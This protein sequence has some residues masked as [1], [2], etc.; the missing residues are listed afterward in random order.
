MKKSTRFTWK[1]LIQGKTTG[2]ENFTMRKTKYNH[3]TI[4]PDLAWECAETTISAQ[5]IDV[6][7]LLKL[8]K[9]LCLSLSFSLFHFSFFSHLASEYF[10]LHSHYCV[11]P[12]MFS[13]SRLLLNSFFTLHTLTPKTHPLISLSLMI[14]IC[15]PPISHY[16]TCSELSHI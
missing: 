3:G 5:Y 15:F 12:Q 9:L 1:T 2:T 4:E 11:Y 8:P 6:Y 14:Y 16:F 13:D 7:S 10:L